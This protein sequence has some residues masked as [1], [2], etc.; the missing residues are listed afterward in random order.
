MGGGNVPF[1]GTEG[2]SGDGPAVRHDE[3]D[4]EQKDDH[5]DDGHQEDDEDVKACREHRHPETFVN[6]P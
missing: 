1:G 3:G 4:G 2:F 6:Q 5:R